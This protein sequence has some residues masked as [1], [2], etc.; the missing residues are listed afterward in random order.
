M[1]G[2]VVFSKRFTRLMTGRI[3]S[4]QHPTDECRRT[5]FRSPEKVEEVRGGGDLERRLA[6]FAMKKHVAPKSVSAF[7]DR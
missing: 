2:I 6:D 4:R 5:G 7:D 3:V 1:L